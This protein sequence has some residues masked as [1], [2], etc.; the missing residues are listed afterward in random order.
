MPIEQQ[1]QLQTLAANCSNVI[2]QSFTNDSLL[3]MKA[4]DAVVSMGGYNTLTEIL[5]LGKRAVVVPRY[6]P[7]Q[8]QLIRTARFAAK[9][10]VTMVHPDDLTARSLIQSVLAQLTHTG[11]LQQE[12]AQEEI[13]LNGLSNIAN[14]L[15]SLV[16]SVQQPVSFSSL[17]LPA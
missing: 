7:S 14:Y 3:Y 16:P 1:L 11:L 5:T 12:A 8:E 4:A 17:C 6:Q 10:W 15:K 13:A 9:G 2:F